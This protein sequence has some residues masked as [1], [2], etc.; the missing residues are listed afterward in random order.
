VALKHKRDCNH[1][2]Q[3]SPSSAAIYS[4]K[5]ARAAL[6]PEKRRKPNDDSASNKQ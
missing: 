2:K 6:C 3:Q 1:L 4:S 5:T